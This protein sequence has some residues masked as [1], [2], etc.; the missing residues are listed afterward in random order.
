MKIGICRSA[1]DFEGIK[2]GRAADY[3]D[4]IS[5]SIRYLKSLVKECEKEL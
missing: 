2:T 4:V 1:D 3:C 5:Q